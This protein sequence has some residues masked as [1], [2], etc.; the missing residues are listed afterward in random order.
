MPLTKV[1]VPVFVLLTAVGV[2]ACGWSRPPISTS[3]G[4][5][6]MQMAI[7]ANHGTYEEEE[8]LRVRVTLTNDS[9][10][11]YDFDEVRFELEAWIYDP[12]DSLGNPGGYHLAP[13]I[14]FPIAPGGINPRD[15]RSFEWTIPGLQAGEY[16][17]C[18]QVVYQSQEEGSPLC[19]PV[20]VGP[21]FY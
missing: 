4:H 16:D 11:P 15:E 9:P 1:F 2:A 7:W 12:P 8:A 18:L 13:L 10:E 6:P 21:W 5:G 20:T 14:S 3:M 19:L 17:I